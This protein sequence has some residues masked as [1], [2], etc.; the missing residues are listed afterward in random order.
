MKP[1]ISLFAIALAFASCDQSGSK[2]GATATTAPAPTVAP[3]PAAKPD[4]LCF[5]QHP[6]GKDLNTVSLYIKGDGVSGIMQ[7]IPW[8][9]DGAE[10][11]LTGVKKGDIITALYSYVIEGSDQKE[12]VVFKLGDKTLTQKSGPMMVTKDGVEVLKDPNTAVFKEVFQQVSC[13]AKKTK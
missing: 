12:E 3:A 10:G 1:S 13:G 8:E 9:K 6:A 7:F 2:T 5:E 4:T 11:T